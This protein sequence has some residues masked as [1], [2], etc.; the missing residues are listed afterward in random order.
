MPATEVL[1]LAGVVPPSVCV[2]GVFYVYLAGR[3]QELARRQAAACEAAVR[4]AEG[5]QAGGA[6]ICDG[7][8]E[9]EAMARARIVRLAEAALA[10]AMDSGRR[11]TGRPHGALPEWQWVKVGHGACTRWLPV[12]LP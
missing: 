9:E 8:D 1:V 3:T 12:C 5:R 7:V 11:H 6:A 10:E 2:C 4:R